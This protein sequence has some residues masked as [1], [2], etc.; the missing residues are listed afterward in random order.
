MKKLF[1]TAL[2]ALTCTMS[3]MLCAQ[4]YTNE[5][6][7]VT[8]AFTSHES[9]N[10]TAEPEDAFLSTNFSYGSNLN[11]PTTFNTNGC[12]A[13]WAAQTLVYF[14]PVTTV[15]KNAADAAENMLE[16]TIT[17]A[18]GIT[19]TPESVSITACTAGGT[20]DPQVTIYA[21]YS[22]DTQETIQARTNPLRPDKENQGDGP[23][24]YS[25]TLENAVAGVLKVR[26][27]FAGLTNTSKGAAVTNIVVTGTVSGTPA[28]STMYTLSTAL[29]LEDAGSVSGAGTYA[30]G[31]STTITATANTGYAF[32]NW[33]KTGDS[34]WTSTTNPL[35]VEVAGD[36][37]YTANFKQLYNVSFDGISAYL[38]SAKNP[39]AGVFYADENDQYTI[40]A[41]A[42]KYLY[43][44]NLT[45][46]GWSDGENTYQSGEQITLA[47]N[48]TLSP[49][50]EATTK[51]LANITSAFSLT[52][53]L[54]HA[55][56]EFNAQGANQQLYY[57]QTATISGQSISIPITIDPTSGKINNVGRS[58]VWAQVN[59]GTIFTIPAVNGMTLVANGYSEFTT[60]TTI[61]GEAITE[62]MLSNSNKTLTYTYEGSDA[63]VDLVVNGPSYMSTIVVS[64][65]VTEDIS[66]EGVNITALTVDGESISIPAELNSEAAEF[67]ATWS[68]ENVYTSVPV[69]VASFNEGADETGLVS[70][71]GTSRTYSFT[72]GERTFNL[73]INNLYIYEPTGEEEA[74]AIKYNEGTVAENIWTNGVY[75]FTTTGIGSSGGADFK[76]DANTDAP[77]TIAVPADVQV[78]QFIIRNFHANY[79]GG[80][81]QLKTVSSEGTTAILP[82]RRTALCNVVGSDAANRQYE[83]EA[84]DLIVNI[85]NHTAGTPV[86]FTMLKSAQPM[87]WIELTTVKVAPT[88]APTKTAESVAVDDNDAVVAVTF[89]REIVNDVEATIND[90]AV[91]AKGGST[92]LYFPAWDLNYASN[93]TLTIATGAAK[94]AYDNVT[95]A[96]IEVAV[97]I[98]AKEEVA[99]AVY[100]YV[101]SNATELLEALAAVEAT[102]KDNKNAAR[103]TIFLKNG[104][105]DLGSSA[106]TVCWVRAHNLS[107]IG[108]S[109]DGVTIHGTST[110]I[111]NPVLNLRYWQGFYLQDL[112]IRNDFDYGT[113]EYNGVSVATY[114]GDKTIMKN[115]RLQSNQDTQ[116]TGDRVYHEDCA[117]HGTVDFICGGGDNYYYH[118]DLVLENRGGNVIVAPSTGASTQ[119]GYV[120]DHCTIKAVD[121]AAA[122][123]NAGSY[124][125][126][127]PWQNEPRA[128][129]LHTTMEIQGATTGWAAMGSL[130]THFYEYDSRDADNNAID[131]SGRTN[132]PTSTNTY[133]PVLTDEEA[134]AFTARN[135]LGGADAWDAAAKAAQVAAPEVAL[136]DNTLSWEAVE[137]A[138]LYVVLKDGAYLTNITETSYDLL[139]S[140]SYSVKAANRFG[141]LGAASAAKQYNAT[142]TS[143]S[144][145]SVAADAQKVIRNG[146]LIII[147]GGM[148]YNTIGQTI[149]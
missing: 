110:G 84:Y 46:A 67:T 52:W 73:T 49:V 106:E 39:L 33:T 81:G 12:K 48:T 87:G 85:E 1:F 18:S 132:S 22:D 122:T 144:S 137:D 93:Y 14:K 44:A 95:D 134:T 35:T 17:P 19:F 45:F 112:T 80:N 130:T 10:A 105:Y 61:A 43:G 58:D 38:A 6:A 140:G 76:F 143:I 68:T 108:E 31:A 88:T 101:I 111:S 129:Y 91:I 60:A 53:D 15:A 146:Q 90:N 32:L 117:I 23:S 51:T 120:F 13:G 47:G 21:V 54:Q 104:D 123:S 69:V 74:V 29:N 116:V 26:L 96:A 70:G 135:V 100:D 99:P 72:K 36:E 121:E 133:T 115:V 86:V 131:L 92:T 63:S 55:Q 102:N 148:E 71:T 64:Y 9:L 138:L 24:V 94:D 77:Y 124:Y 78:K 57:T 125:L 62:D 41:Y 103:K 126:G 27:Y 37:T 5:D 3:Q 119:W 66:A 139:E 40:P 28:A 59:N 79:S 97:T 113:G 20:G 127:R 50:F 65:P 141:G 107:L 82:T 147:R 42:H 75:T 7:T 142:V 83:G 89:D 4:T 25:K 2:C 118:T 136:N 34:E 98:P 149:K 16:W 56:I 109:R 145:E 11:T 114:G 30:E 128:Y 8:W